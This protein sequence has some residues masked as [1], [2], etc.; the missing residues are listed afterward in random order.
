MA[1][2]DVEQKPERRRLLLWGAALAGVI[3][4]GV[5]GARAASSGRDLDTPS[6]EPSRAPY[7]PAGPAS[8]KEA[9]ERQAFVMSVVNDIDA[10]WKWDFQ[11]RTAKYVAV[12]PVLVD[13]PSK[14]DCGPGIVLGRSDCFGDQRVFIDLSFLRGLDARFDD[15]ANGAK[16]YAIAHEMGHHVQRVLGMDKKLQALLEEKP[17]STHWAEVQ[18]ELQADCFAGVWVRRA[19]PEHLIEPTQIES[20]IRH[21]SELG[22]ARH[23]ARP[24]DAEHVGESFTYAIPRRRIYWFAQGYAHG[25]IDDCDTFAP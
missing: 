2:L 5:A 1:S 19:G 9:A 6:A 3:G 7:V 8:A 10:M 11:R 24:A 13:F 23:L 16:V 20:S 25:E 22:T 21:T 18:L 15:E 12:E 14:S 4:L 17:V